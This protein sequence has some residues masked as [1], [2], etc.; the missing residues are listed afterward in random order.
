MKKKYCGIISFLLVFILMIFSACSQ[1]N[2]SSNGNNNIVCQH[3]NLTKIS[4]TATC[5]V[6]GVVT[7][8]CNQCGEIIEMKSSK[9]A[10]DY[11]V[12]VSDSTTCEED[13]F[14]N[15]KCSTCEAI[16]ST[17]KKATGHNG[18]INCSNCEQSFYILLYNNLKHS[19]STGTSSSGIQYVIS[20][21]YSKDEENR[22]HIIWETTYEFPINSSTTTEFIIQK[23]GSWTYTTNCTLQSGY[24]SAKGDLMGELSYSDLDLY[25]FEN[26][27]NNSIELPVSATTNKEMVDILYTGLKTDFCNALR[28]LLEACI[29]NGKITMPNLGF[30]NFI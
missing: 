13:G 21:K 15:Y 25:T 12:F 8:R 24:I 20:V 17:P 11:A 1:N 4:D 9:K 19:T 10:H 27:D 26:V 22:L 30:K 6:D 2:N 16:K 23:N 7:S 18:V 28:K 29:N 3:N 5:T 14:I